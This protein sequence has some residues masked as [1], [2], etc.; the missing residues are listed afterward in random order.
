LLALSIIVGNRISLDVLRAKYLRQLNI[1]Q[2]AVAEIPGGDKVWL[3][4]V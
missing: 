4:V 2:Y 3:L 1:Q